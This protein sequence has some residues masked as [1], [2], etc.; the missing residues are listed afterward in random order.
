MLRL[1]GR[2]ADINAAM[3][4]LARN[5]H[6]TY[7]RYKINNGEAAAWLNNNRVKLHMF[8]PIWRKFLIDGLNEE[9]EDVGNGHKGSTSIENMNEI[10]AILSE[11]APAAAP[12]NQTP[13]AAPVSKQ[14]SA[15]ALVSEPPG[16][17][18]ATRELDKLIDKLMENDFA[19]KAKAKHHLLFLSSEEQPPEKKRK[20]AKDLTEI[21][22]NHVNV[23]AD[24]LLAMY[25]ISILRGNEGGYRRRTK[26]SKKH[27]KKSRKTK[28]RRH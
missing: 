1:T 20:E 11:Q 10:I 12:A 27:S 21:M 25:Y 22:I 26:N 14:T 18:E 17:Q 6:A 4:A 7:T 8:S 13:A 3:E 23:L 19:L 24:R 5:I 28:S 16:K 15:A 9:I 2:D